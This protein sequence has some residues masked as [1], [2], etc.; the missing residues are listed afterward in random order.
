MKIVIQCAAKKDPNAGYLTNGDGKPVLF[1]ANPDKAP[2][3]D[4]YLYARPDD[5]TENG[6]TWRELLVDYN[7]RAGNNP[8]NL[9]PAYKLYS[10]TTYERLVKQY[11]VDNIF[12]LSAGWGLIS[13]KFLTP[14]YDITFA[15]TPKDQ[16]YKQRSQQDQ[17]H[18]FCLLPN[19]SDDALVFFGG[20]GYLPL[21][22]ELTQNYQ[23]HR[24]VFYNSG[25]Q[26]ETPGCTLIRYLTTTRTNWHY[27]CARDFMSGKIGV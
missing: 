25:V 27:S 13:A 9:S 15:Q 19:D 20:K 26:P 11:G 10:N 6:K 12:I 3:S 7:N 21:F 22:C 2:P 14:K 5:L 8:L 23:G 24:F 16:K 18:D 4:A 1:V 17:Y